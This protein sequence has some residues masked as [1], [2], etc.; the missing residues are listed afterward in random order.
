[1]EGAVTR[2]PPSWCA[3]PNPCPARSAAETHAHLQGKLL[4]SMAAHAWQSQGR[5]GS[6]CTDCVLFKQTQLGVS[7]DKLVFDLKLAVQSDRV[8]HSSAR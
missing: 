8:Q 7:K 5:K 6:T 4:R 3:V 1:M 2:G